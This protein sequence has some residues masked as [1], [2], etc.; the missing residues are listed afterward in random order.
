MRTASVTLLLIATLL[1]FELAAQETFPSLAP[2]PKQSLKAAGFDIEVFGDLK[3]FTLTS[4]TSKVAEGLEVLALTLRSAQPASPP[5]F[6]IKWSLPSHDVAGHWMTGRGQTK[7]IRPDWAG[8][9]LQASMLAREAPVSCLFSSDDR[10]VLT[11]AVSDALN[12]ISSGSGVREEDGM[13]YNEVV[14]FA[15]RHK[16][17]TD[18]SVQVRIDRRSVPYETVLHDVGEWWAAMPAYAPAST[19][20][21]A[22]L[23]VYSTWYNYHQ[24]VDAAVLL[25]EVA[26]A[27]QLGYASIIVD[28][29]WQTL[30]SRRGYAFTGDWEPER[31]PD[32]KG[33]VDECHRLG[34]KVV[35]WYAVPFMGK[36]A[37]AAARFKDRTLRFDE[38]LGTYVLD[39]RYAEVRQYLVDTY[40]RAIR[41]WGIDGFKLDFIE[42]FVADDQTVLEATDGRDYA[43]VNE[44]ADRLM[45]DVMAAVRRLN[46]EVMIEFRQAYIGPL[47]RKYG[48]M[49]RA[50][51]SPNAYVANKVKTIDLRLLSG[52]TAVHADMIMWHDREPVEL[53]AFQFLNILFSV[54]QLSV[55]LHEIP[56]DHFAMV[57]FYTE[58]WLANR[59][60]LLDAR[61][62][63]PNPLA[64]YPLVRARAGDKQIIALYGD[65]VAR[66]GEPTRRIDLVNAKHSRGVIVTG[67]KAAGTYTYVVR[68][69]QGR[70]GKTGELFLGPTP[71]ELEVPVSGIVSL[72]RRP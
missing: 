9:R 14:F 24:N 37:K 54:P 34:V 43:S 55:R 53:A 13:I 44:A 6:S 68:D 50:S 23:P 25:K 33:F 8:G 10:N 28:D 3:G 41:E 69:C 42:R 35:L 46:P 47:I 19:P 5:R 67:A 11:F 27:K 45:T 60:V 57:K 64:N 58:Y 15:E 30:D 61:V 59:D 29:G 56:K 39:P 40:T 2:Q 26:V 51:D 36:N 1:D 20:A 62:E 17:L 65:V 31:M 16:A 63:A 18:Y 21:P 12:T 7:T 52:A 32:M 49:F 72:E 22:R 48:N 38:R 66:L 70:A 4:E 71:V